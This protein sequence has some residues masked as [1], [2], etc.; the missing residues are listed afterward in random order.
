MKI[1]YEATYT[2]IDK[3][4]IRGRLKAAGAKLVKPEFM[5]KRIVFDLPA[6]HK[7]PGGWLRVRDEG[8]QITMSLKTVSGQDITSQKETCFKID[9]FD[10]GVDFFDCLGCQRKSYQESRRELWILDQVEITID[11]WPYLE[12]L[13]EIEGESEDAVKNIST[14]LG[15]DYGQARFCSVDK[16]YH[17]KYGTPLHDINFNTKR[18]TFSDP[19]PFVIIK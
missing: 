7:V 19:N 8:D 17:D 16:L 18:R 10:E 12:P 2:N 5:M 4:E 14:R 13:V 6:E 15:F 1:E 9:N 3:A 11:E